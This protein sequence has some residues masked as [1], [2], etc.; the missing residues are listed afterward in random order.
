MSCTDDPTTTL[1]RMVYGSQS[2]G[3]KPYLAT[4]DYLGY[5]RLIDQSMKHGPFYS[6][7]P[8]GQC[9]PIMYN[10]IQPNTPPIAPQCVES[11]RYQYWYTT[12]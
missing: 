8:R 10:Y 12:Q 4:P 2:K 6:T 3:P 5:V 1:F 7:A 9:F 11:P